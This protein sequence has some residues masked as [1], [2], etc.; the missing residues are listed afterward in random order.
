MHYL[1]N[2]FL[3]NSIPFLVLNVVMY[4]VFKNTRK[5]VS[6]RTMCPTYSVKCSYYQN[7][8]FRVTK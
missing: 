4:W 7:V 6:H 2:R 8:C 1:D 5:N 3:L